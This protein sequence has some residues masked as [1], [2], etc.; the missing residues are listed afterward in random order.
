MPESQLFSCGSLLVLEGTLSSANAYSQIWA[1]VRQTGSSE[2]SLSCHSVSPKWH[3]PETFPSFQVF[4]VWE[5]NNTDRRRAIRI[6]KLY[7]HSFDLEHH[8]TLDLPDR[9][10]G[11]SFWRQ[12][13]H[14]E[15]E[16]PE[17]VDDYGRSVALQARIAG[18]LLPSHTRNAATWAHQ[19]LARHSENRAQMS[20]LPK[21]AGASR[22][23]PIAKETFADEERTGGCCCFQG[24]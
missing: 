22:R 13:L 17:H 21:C 6:A 7:R 20:L 1:S 18:I 14:S 12:I 9:R 23:A 3:I 8:Y 5:E 15:D 11:S 4:C 16:T 10:Q 24:S 19:D 2:S